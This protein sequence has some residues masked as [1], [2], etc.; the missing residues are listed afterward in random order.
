MACRAVSRYCL[1]HLAVSLKVEA[2]AQTDP[3]TQKPAEFSSEAWDKLRPWVKY[4]VPA[5]RPKRILDTTTSSSLAE[6]GSAEEEQ[7]VL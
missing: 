5:F 4:Y 7:V 3:N 6:G 2:S 1:H